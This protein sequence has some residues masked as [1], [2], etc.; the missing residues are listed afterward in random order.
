MVEMGV[1]SAGV[2]AGALVSDM[3]EWKAVKMVFA[4][5]EWTADWKATVLVAKTVACWG[6]RWIE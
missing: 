2:L 1:H 5:E 4:P 3:A 6:S